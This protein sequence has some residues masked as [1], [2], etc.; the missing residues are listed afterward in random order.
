MKCVVAIF[1]GT[2]VQKWTVPEDISIVGVVGSGDLSGVVSTDPTVTADGI[3]NTQQIVDNLIAFFRCAS[4]ASAG[5]IPLSWDARK[6]DSIYF[7]ANNSGSIALF[8][9]V[10]QL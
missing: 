1:A 9:L 2:A 8:Y 4:T 5:F 10:T 6:D 7:S 3:V